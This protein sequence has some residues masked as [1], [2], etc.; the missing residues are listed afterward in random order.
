MFSIKLNG[1]DAMVKKL[2][3][4]GV[5]LPVNQIDKDVKEESLKVVEKLKANYKSRHVDT[6]QLVNSISS[7]RRR[8]KGKDDPYFTYYV[9]PRF[10]G[11]FKGN[12]AYLLEYGTVERFRANAKKGGVGMTKDGKRTDL[13]SVYG[14]KISTGKITP[15]GVIRYT[16]DSIRSGIAS[17][18]AKKV[19]KALIDKWNKSK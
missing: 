18:L 1:L 9:G 8:R 6:G 19:E 12:Q 15:T 13:K 7:F 17:E 3:D 11:E 2:K 14:A 16:S 5:N 4:Q 10:G